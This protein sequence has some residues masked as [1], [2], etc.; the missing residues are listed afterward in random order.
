MFKDKLAFESVNNIDADKDLQTLNE[1][2][3]S[4]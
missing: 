3:H 1:Y 4:K 2:V